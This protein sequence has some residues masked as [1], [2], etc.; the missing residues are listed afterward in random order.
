MPNPIHQK[1]LIHVDAASDAKSLLEG[2]DPGV[3]KNLETFKGIAA[4]D[5]T[6]MNLFAHS[7][8]ALQQLEAAYIRGK[9]MYTD[10]NIEFRNRVGKTINAR[11][12]DGKLE[13]AI[14]IR[15]GIEVNNSDD[16]I[17]IV[18]DTGADLSASYY[19]GQMSCA[20]EGC[21]KE[22][23]A[24]GFWFMSWYECEDG[25]CVGDLLEDSN[26]RVT[27]II[28]TIED[29]VELSF[30]SGGANLTAE[31]TG[32]I[33]DQL[34]Q[35]VGTDLTFMRFLAESNGYN[36]DNAC[37]K[38][39]IDNRRRSAP[40]PKPNPKPPKKGDDKP[41]ST[42]IKDF[43]NPDW[44]LIQDS[45]QEDLIAIIKEFADHVTDLNDSAEEAKTE[46]YEKLAKASKAQK[47]ELEDAKPL[48]EEH[49][50]LK[51]I[52]DAEVKYWQD[53]CIE[54]KQNVRSYSDDDP[55]LLEYAESV[56]KITDI[57]ELRNK[58]VGHSDTIAALSSAKTFLELQQPNA[59]QPEVQSNYSGS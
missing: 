27:G 21:G 14:G 51:A 36:F 57:N 49:G 22:L 30:V 45:D 35:K 25:H 6:T 15:P 47:K 19:P 34:T 3:Y 16:I 2:I 59:D 28:D 44:S 54:K 20:V 24:Y 4:D 23:M 38:F 32:E 50:T 39:G 40:R 37:M 31:V 17:T 53:K 56:R 8:K 13:V 42:I 7:P 29:V 5:Q 48:I 10:H 9:G 12:V 11:I 33:S 43:D 58:T 26:E 46:E 52:V 18:R 41:V 1:G 55:R